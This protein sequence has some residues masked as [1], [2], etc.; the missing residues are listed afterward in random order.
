MQFRFLQLLCEGHNARF[1]EYLHT[2][3]GKSTTVNLV[4]TTV[5]YLLLM[6]ESV[7]SFCW[8][9]NNMEHIEIMGQ[10]NISCAFSVIKQ[11]LIT[12]TEYIQG[13]CKWNQ[14]ALSRSRL[15]DAIQGLL[16]L[17]AY[18]Q[19]QLSNTNSI[20][21]LREV[22]KVL[23]DM[24]T[25]LLSMLEG[26]QM[27]SEIG[28][29][30]KHTLVDCRNE[31]QYI[32][33]FCFM[34][35]KLNDTITSKAFTQY[36]TNKDGRISRVEFERALQ[37]QK[38]YSAEEV[39]YLMICGDTNRDGYIDYTEFLDR[40]LL[41]AEEIGFNLVVL[42]QNLF[43]HLPKTNSDFELNDLRNRGKELMEHFHNHL[44]SIEIIGKSKT[45]E[46]VYFQIPK[47]CRDQWGRSQIQE[48]KRE[49]INTCDH[50]NVNSK[51]DKFI[52]FSENTI[53]EMRHFGKLCQ[54]EE[55]ER[56]ARAKYH[57][58]QN[59]DKFRE[60][61]PGPLSE[62]STTESTSRGR[63][64]TAAI[65][66][67]G[68][69]LFLNILHILAWCGKKAAGLWLQ[70][71]RKKKPK[72]TTTQIDNGQACRIK[73][74][75]PSNMCTIPGESTLGTGDCVELEP[76]NLMYEAEKFYEKTK[77]I[78]V[79][80]SEEYRDLKNRK[81]SCFRKFCEYLRDLTQQA[82]Y[83]PL[84]IQSNFKFS[85]FLV[86]NEQTLKSLRFISVILMNF[87]L[88]FYYQSSENL[89]A[90]S[91][92]FILNMV[93]SLHILLCLLLLYT[94]IMW[95]VPLE[96]FKREKKICIE[97]LQDSDILKRFLGSHRKPFLTQYWWDSWALKSEK[98][99]RMYWDKH[100]KQKVREKY[101]DMDREEEISQLLGENREGQEGKQDE[102]LDDV[103]SLNEL[104]NNFGVDYYYAIWMLFRVYIS[105]RNLLFSLMYICFTCMGILFDHFF[106]AFHLLPEMMAYFSTLR[107]VVVSVTIHGK[108]LVYTTLL[109][110][111]VIFI[112]TVFAFRFFT[113]YYSNNCTDMLS[114]LLFHLHHAV[115]A[116]GGVSDV[117]A[118]PNT[119]DSFVLPRFFFDMSFFFIVIVFLLAIIQGLIIDAFGE[120]RDRE[121]GVRASMQNKCFICGI[122]K[123][124]FNQVPRGYETHTNKEHFYPNYL[125]F[126]MYLI[127]KHDTLYT[128]Q[129]S[130]VW[131]LYLKRKWDFF[132]IGCYFEQ[133]RIEQSMAENN[134]T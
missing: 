57:R 67:N 21:L 72:P 113:V 26:N 6:Q 2:Q 45:V 108:R 59:R 37:S 46:K 48:A 85:S 128:G 122:N 23:S 61:Q 52:D 82:H 10:D 83:W 9:Y 112:Y 49:F 64:L 134:S 101:S 78:P 41:R 43:E 30:M 129:E 99:P 8:H 115:R 31:L 25:L 100:F 33:K 121:E 15:W 97:I 93:A 35:I 65:K 36:D 120:L 86:E 22:L 47:S 66:A 114:C 81:Y 124:K 24:I 71:M 28:V 106:F 84:I 4:Q 133:S 117:I 13:P 39:D 50:E 51:L 126:I 5:D 94:Y 70:L 12:L 20:E 14:T 58:D 102:E 18:L 79:G 89:F 44:G 92:T 40:F 7:S 11:V 88:L 105:D 69:A 104:T 74:S 98:F 95:K 96:C 125:F 80:F 55:W 127:N 109:M 68:F 107:T 42:L 110:S 103:H 73:D 27:S 1:Q 19:V 54:V 3:A 123:D 32:T 116:G 87:F 16:R 34:F 131:E 77:I 60:I 91:Y 56:E 38:Q 118:P 75:L 29:S 119:N 17:F 130:Y 111:A 63:A 76:S 90:Y 53:F 132:P 62:E